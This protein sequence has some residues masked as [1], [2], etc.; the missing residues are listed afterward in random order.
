MTTKLIKLIAFGTTLVFFFSLA[1]ATPCTLHDDTGQLIHLTQPATRI[2]SLAPDS[3]E[4][5]F[6]IGAE[7]KI[8]GVISGSDYPAAAKE[9]PIIGSYMGLDLE[10]IIALHPDLIVTW[11][12]LFS[13]QLDALKKMAI[14]IYTVEP[15]KLEDIPRTLKNLGCL[16]GNEK[17]ANQVADNF[18]KQLLVLSKQY[19]HEK[20][21]TVFYQIGAD[22][23]ITINKESWINEVISLCGG[24]NIFANVKTLAPEID[25]ESLIVADPQVIISDA[26]NLDWRNYWQ[27]WPQLT[28]VKKQAL[29]SINPDLIDRASPRLLQ[30]AAQMCKLINKNSI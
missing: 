14:P 29:F 17:T 6:A 28:A 30:G 1:H 8:I 23:L 7:K 19:A 10:R 4:N 25:W 22:S 5:L 13:R 15:K 12:H 3:T 24:Q 27:R 16:T 26:I 9:I 2:I 21:V 11:G 18:S 20:K